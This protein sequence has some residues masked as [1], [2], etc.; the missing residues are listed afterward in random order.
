VSL[1][2]RLILFFFVT[3]LGSALSSIATFLS[4]EHYFQS[5]VLLGVALSVRTLA[6]AIFSY[7]SNDIIQKLGLMRSLMASQV[8]GCL[9]LAVLF[10]GFHFDSFVITIIGIIL[11]G[12][13]STF[14]A[15]L[16]TII[17]RISAENSDLFRKY[18]GRRELVFG[19]AML[20]SSILAPVLLWKY[21]LNFL[22]LVDSVSYIVGFVLLLNLNLDKQATPEDEE[23]KPQRLVPLLLASKHAKEY[24]LKTSASLLLAGLLP[25]L[26]SSAQIQF[27]MDMPLLLRQ[28]LWSI[29][30]ITAISASLIYLLLTM[31][32]KHRFFDAVVMLSGVWLIIP[33]VSAHHYSIIISAVMICLLTDLSGQKFR[34]DLIVNAGND[35]SLIKSYSALSLFQRN[36]IFFISPIL[37]SILI[38]Y[39]SVWI[40]VGIIV[41]MQI[42]LYAVHRL[43]VKKPSMEL[44]SNQ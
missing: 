8:F 31:V 36:F 30:D 35:S 27:T 14:V 43:I 3:S 32:R 10:L 11:T 38:A 23:K 12:L 7:Y 42:G 33:I 9:A 5:L 26:A 20:L 21:N 39:T 24:M 22:L 13:P 40:S 2:N 1:Q 41:F 44:V 4:I 34:D 18:S 15:T 28:W 19:V 16:I 37:L 25:L 17:L 6:S 29:E